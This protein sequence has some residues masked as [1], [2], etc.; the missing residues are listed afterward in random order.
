MTHDERRP[1]PGSG[2]P[3]GDAAGGERTRHL[4]LDGLNAYLDG[5]LPPR[6]QTAAAAH[7]AT[8][9][10]CRA[11]LAELRA[12]V[13]LLRG[14]PQY[15]PRRSFRLGP[16]QAGRHPADDGFGRLLSFLPA[17]RLAA[18]A[19]AAALVLVTI[20][21]QLADQGGGAGGPALEREAPVITAGAPEEEAAPAP[22]PAQAPAPAVAPAAAPNAG[23]EPAA[24]TS[25]E[26]R[27]APDGAE[28]AP[29]ALNGAGES[30]S[31][32]PDA[33][34]SDSRPGEAGATTERARPS[35]WRLAQV[36]LA[37]AL[38]W[39]LVGLVGLSVL[40]RQQRRT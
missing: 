28:G 4:D 40:R 37:L 7:V 11:E 29:P 20:A 18:V 38:L 27:E 26:M 25:L 16:E 5:A 24:E 3:G 21:G 10:D 15:A 6:D 35:G 1:G 14:L 30:V 2:T 23:T 39:L 12:T 36:G 34:P 17:V 33:V 9:P 8:C 22:A 31:A 19:T 13:A 32:P